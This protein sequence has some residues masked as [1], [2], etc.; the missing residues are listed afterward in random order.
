MYLGI[1]KTVLENLKKKQQN[2]K[3]IFKVAL[4][5]KSGT[6]YPWAFRIKN[7][8]A[9]HNSKIQN[10]YLQGFRKDFC[11]EDLSRV[12]FWLIFQ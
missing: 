8:Y 4:L 5:T 6:N 1:V 2:K 12:N 3:Q 9:F 7:G 10:G 11:Y